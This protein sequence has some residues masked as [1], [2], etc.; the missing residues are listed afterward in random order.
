MNKATA[1]SDLALVDRILQDVDRTLH[2]PPLI[3]LTWGL[4]AAI[5]NGVAQARTVG[6]PVPSDGSFQ[7][8]ADAA[9]DRHQRVGRAP[10]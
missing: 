8:S 7:T 10:S 5:V 3:L 6:L 2:M 1:R 9:R 4:F